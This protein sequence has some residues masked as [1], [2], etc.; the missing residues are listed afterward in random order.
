[1]SQT[2]AIAHEC[3][4]LER[5]LRQAAPGDDPALLALVVELSSRVGLRRRPSVMIIDDEGSPFVCGPRRPSLVLPRGLT[6][7]AR[8]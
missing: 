2:A 3:S 5:L 8:P 6:L 4:R 1:M 7:L